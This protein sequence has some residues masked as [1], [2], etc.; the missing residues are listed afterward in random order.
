MFELP[1]TLNIASCLSFICVS[2][3]TNDLFVSRVH[4]CGK[5]FSFLSTNLS[6]I[7]IYEDNLFH[8]LYHFLKFKGD[9]GEGSW[10]HRNRG[11][12]QLRKRPRR[13]ILNSTG[14]LKCGNKREC[15]KGR[16]EQRPKAKKGNGKRP[17]RDKEGVWMGKPVQKDWVSSFWFI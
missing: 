14:K 3:G 4:V 13:R 6:E 5:I 10:P 8:I 2:A 15:G 17:S 9:G 1:L 12:V 16:W 11:N 7:C